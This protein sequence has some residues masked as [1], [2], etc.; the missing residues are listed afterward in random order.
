MTI[1]R[2]TTSSAE[3]FFSPTCRRWLKLWL[4]HS[5]AHSLVYMSSRDPISA[6]A[7]FSSSTRT[8]YRFS[9]FFSSPGNGRDVACICRRGRGLPQENDHV[10][11][12]DTKISRACDIPLTRTILGHFCFLIH[13]THALST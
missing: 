8:G 12:R 9:L 4:P 1:M 13:I 5:L 3:F 6:H 10:V 11:H 2:R 7:L